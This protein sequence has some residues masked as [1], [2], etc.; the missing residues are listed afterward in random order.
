MAEQVFISIGFTRKTHGV[1]GELKC[2]VGE[3]FEEIVT[4]KGRVFLD[5]RGRKLPYFVESIR[6]AGEPIIKFEDVNNREDALLL[7]ARE[8][9]LLEADLPLDFI[10]EDEEELVFGYLKGYGLVD[11]TLGPVGV[12]DEVMEMP[13][14]EMAVVRYKGR[15]VLIPLNERLITKID[16]AERKVWLDL[17]EGLLDM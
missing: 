1:K 7:Q 10:V 13:Q 8:M 16:E 6:G 11:K 15:E 12:I 2:S 5:Q 14:Q 3:D 4:K 9:F 17:P